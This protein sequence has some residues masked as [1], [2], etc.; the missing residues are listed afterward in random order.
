MSSHYGAVKNTV[1]AAELQLTAMP[2]NVNDIC[3]NYIRLDDYSA[4]W[5]R[6]GRANGDYPVVMPVLSRDSSG[7]LMCD[8]SRVVRLP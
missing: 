5:Q 8:S 1:S 4:D 3:V 7:L 6:L 2:Y